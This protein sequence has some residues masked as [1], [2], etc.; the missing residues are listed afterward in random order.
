MFI[1]KMT[2]EEKVSILSKPDGDDYLRRY[3]KALERSRHSFAE[4]YLLWPKS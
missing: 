1:E 3:K 4:P 2:I